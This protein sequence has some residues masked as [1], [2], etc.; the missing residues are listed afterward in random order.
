MIGDLIA[1]A[2]AQVGITEERVSRWI[3][4]PCNC[5]A[6]KDKLNALS[7][8]AVRVLKGQTDQALDYLRR[9]LDDESP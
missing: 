9:L 8:W 7:F 1:Q 6:R 3:G 5:R 4:S 2:L